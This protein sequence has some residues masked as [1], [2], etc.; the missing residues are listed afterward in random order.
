MA[1]GRFRMEWQ[2]FGLALALPFGFICNFSAWFKSIAKI[3]A[4]GLIP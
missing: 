3:G 1:P 4:A 2:A